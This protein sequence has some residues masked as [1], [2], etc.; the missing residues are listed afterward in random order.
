MFRY[1]LPW[2]GDP[3]DAEDPL[4]TQFRPVLYKARTR[5]ARYKPHNVANV[6]HNAWQMV[7]EGCDVH[8]VA[9]RLR[10][11]RVFMHV[12]DVPRDDV[13]HWS[14][15]AA[16]AAVA[17]AQQALPLTHGA[18]VEVTQ[19]MLKFLDAEEVR[20]FQA[21][22]VWPLPSAPEDLHS[23]SN[24][25][26]NSNNHDMQGSSSIYDPVHSSSAVIGGIE[27]V[28]GGLE[29]EAPAW[30]QG[31][32]CIGRIADVYRDEKRFY[33]TGPY[34]D[35][36]GYRALPG[37]CATFRIAFQMN[38]VLHALPPC[39]APPHGAAANGSGE[40]YVEAFVQLDSLGKK[41]L[42]QVRDAIFTWL[43][44]ACLLFQNPPEVSAG[45]S[46]SIL[47][48]CSV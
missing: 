36:L 29:N 43:P 28:S 13:P 17:T 41:E 24:G 18:S 7:L 33:D 10:G 25:N 16:H 20:D 37:E 44:V 19:Q 32:T 39:E 30:L 6:Q 3:S 11:W 34:I 31:A 26:F 35:A 27:T 8:V 46:C 5:R 4:A 15:H 2:T 38:L 21:Y 45:V 47:A 14:D 48:H 12:A 23:S 1:L 9:Q 40:N 22:I 42:L